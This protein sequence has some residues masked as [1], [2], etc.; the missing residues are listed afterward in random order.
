MRALL[1]AVDKSRLAGLQ[2]GVYGIAMTLLVLDVRLPAV[3]GDV[4]DA[5]LWLAVAGAWPK[6]L[7]WLLSFWVLAVFWL[8]DARALA[9]C[10]VIDGT[11]LRI[12]LMRL[13]LVSLL[14]FSTALI[15]AH[16]DHAPAAAIYAGHLLLIALTRT[17]R[18][19][20]LQRHP[21][22]TDWPDPAARLGAAINAWGTVAC[23]LVAFGLAFV[24]P[25][26]NMLA[27]LPLLLLP[28]I[29]RS[30]TPPPGLDAS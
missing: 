17:A 19:A 18:H 25:G 16:G 8:D 26:Y 7:T 21:D 28:A 22:A 15:A 14:P 20:Y 10:R 23:M 11:L 4:T 9:A 30:W 24:V 29:R 1:A 12:G 13:A 3:P 5:Q 6:L 27:L 2:D